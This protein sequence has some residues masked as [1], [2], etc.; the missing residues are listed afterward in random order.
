MRLQRRHNVL[1]TYKNTSEDDDDISDCSVLQKVKAS[2]TRKDMR[3]YEDKLIR[4]VFNRN[5]GPDHR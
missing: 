4:G 3:P 5:W 1:E 2:K